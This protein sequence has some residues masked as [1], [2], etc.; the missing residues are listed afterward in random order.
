MSG[1]IRLGQLAGRPTLLE[2]ACCQCERR[3]RLVGCAPGGRARGGHAAAGAA[4]DS[5]G[6][7]PA[8]GGVGL[9]LRA[10]RRA[11]S[12]AGGVR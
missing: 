9:D 12:A 1:A 8:A 7:L 5:V 10:M 4:A 3:G 2:V 6:R 11:F